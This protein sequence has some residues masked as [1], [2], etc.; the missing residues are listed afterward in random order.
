MD[1]AKSLVNALFAKKEPWQIAAISTMS[2]L[3]AVWLF[4][5]ITKEES[6][7]SS[8]YQVFTQFDTKWLIHQW[9]QALRLE[10]KGSSLS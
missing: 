9:F 3:F 6:E 2:T 4:Q 5:F 7:L 1:V 8:S 10:P